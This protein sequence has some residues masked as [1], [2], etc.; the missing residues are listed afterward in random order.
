MPCPCDGSGNSKESARLNCGKLGRSKQRPSQSTPNATA[1][2][3]AGTTCR[4]P[5]TATAEVNGCPVPQSGIGRYRVETV[6]FVDYSERR[7]SITSIR[8]ARAAGSTE[9]T[10]AAA[11]RTAALAITGIVSGM[12]MSTM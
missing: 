11:S 6:V 10:T 7:A 2:A 9:A 1:K 4:A 5:T 8:A 3:K 12:R